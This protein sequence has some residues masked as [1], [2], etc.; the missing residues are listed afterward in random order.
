MT[1]LHVNEFWKPH[2]F[3][4]LARVSF[5]AEPHQK[6]T[7]VLFMDENNVLCKNVKADIIDGKIGS[8]SITIGLVAQK[9]YCDI[10]YLAIFFGK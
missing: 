8:N 10:K 1:V 6:I 7:E 5:E 3:F 2:T 4:A 9:I